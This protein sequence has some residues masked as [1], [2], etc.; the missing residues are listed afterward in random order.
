M[1]GFINS[2]PADAICVCLPSLSFTGEKPG[3]RFFS[4]K[5][6]SLMLSGVATSSLGYLNKFGCGLIGGNVSYS[7]F[8]MKL[9]SGAL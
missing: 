5:Y 2:L 4:F 7:I 8:V 1:P 3:S 9:D 6:T